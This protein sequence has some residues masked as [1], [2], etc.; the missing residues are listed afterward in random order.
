MSSSI[1]YDSFG[2]V[3]TGSIQ[4]RYTYTGREFEEEIGLTY[5]RAHWYD[6]SAGRFTSEDT[7]GLIGGMNSYAYV[8][9]GPTTLVDPVGLQ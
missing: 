5:Y 1:G 3:V 8:G 6:S 4:S 2:N 7:I 9:N